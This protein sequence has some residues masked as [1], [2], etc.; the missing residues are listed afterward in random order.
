MPPRLRFFLNL[1]GGL[2]AVAG[3]VFVGIR[4]Q[5]YLGDARLSDVNSLAW[6]VIA[7]SI[8][9]Y[10]L[11]NALLALAYRR[12][13]RVC[14]API[15]AGSALRLYGISQLAKYVPG[16]I[17][18]L[19]GR[20]ALGAKA[21]VG[22]KALAKA[23]AMEIACLALVAASFAPF[24][25]QAIFPESSAFIWISLWAFALV[26]IFLIFR[27]NWGAYSSRIVLY[28]AAFFWISGSIFAALI[29]ALQSEMPTNRSTLLCGSF[30]LAWLAG[31]L[32]PGAPAGLGV[33][34]LVLLVLIGPHVPEATLLLAI[35]LGRIVT[36]SGDFLAFVLVL[37]IRWS[38]KVISNSNIQRG[39]A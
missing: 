27:S 23:T 30:V 14:Q 26:V 36:I 21:G 12:F 8:V 4:L 28:H 19:A 24:A 25:C 38:D 3:I 5:A 16:N 20:Q 31:F 32:T 11:G 22:Q 37:P 10:G 15:G 33:R 29:F 6:I 34:E 35:L 13:L 18:H 39:A 2:L 7:A 17:L 9:I 1:V